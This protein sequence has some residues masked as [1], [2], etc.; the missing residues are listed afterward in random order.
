MKEDHMKNGQLKVAYNVQIST[1]NQILTPFSIHQK[2]TYF[3]TLENHLEVFKNAYGK[4]SKQ[5]IADARY[6]K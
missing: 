5:I 3:T 2:S 4:N 1:D 6:G